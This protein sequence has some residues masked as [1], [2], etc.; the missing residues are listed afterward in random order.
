[1]ARAMRLSLPSWMSQP[2]R[3]PTKTRR[4][5]SVLRMVPPAPRVGP[6]AKRSPFRVRF[7]DRVAGSKASCW[8][9]VSRKTW[10]PPEGVALNA[11]LWLVS[12]LRERLPLARAPKATRSTSASGMV[13]S[14]CMSLTALKAGIPYS[15]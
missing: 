12:Y 10:K 15:K 13:P 3:T 14:S 4:G 8:K 1:M 6:K 9:G 2:V 5:F 7:R 11:G